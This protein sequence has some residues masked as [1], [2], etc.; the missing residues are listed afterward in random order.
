MLERG[1][2]AAGPL[3]VLEQSPGRAAKPSGHLLH[4]ARAGGGIGHLGEVR[5]LDQHQLGIARNPTREA[6]GQAERRGER[7]HGDGVGAA[8]AGGDDR[9]GRPQHVHVRI[10]PRHHPP[11]GLGSDQGGR[12]REPASLL[13]AR[14]E[15]A[16]RAQ[17]GDGQELIGIG[18]EAEIDHA[19]G[20]IEG[21]PAGFQRTQIFHSRCQHVG[22]LL[23]L[24][25]AGIV[26]DAAVGSRERPA[27]AL[28]CQ[29]RDD[30]VE[31]RLE[32][33]PGQWTAARHG[34]GADR[35]EAET[36][37]GRRRRDPS[38]LR[39]GS[40]QLPGVLGR[41]AEIEIE[42]DAGVEMDAVERAR[43]SL[44]GCRKTIAV[45]AD[46]PGKDEGEAGRAILEI[47]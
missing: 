2:G 7:Q 18:G 28:A 10:A 47:V 8:E 25:A 23:R 17:L 33:A 45:A 19:A 24:R 40:E 13:D 46:R 36:D 20:G 30:R 4:A 39:Q 44:S 42:R 9:D 27:K 1:P 32:G 16:Q 43:N 34:R 5:F 41:R 6:V 29:I 11:G 21:D 15:L 3:D 26:D 22:E 35:I 14:P 31:D 38:L 37:I 12:R